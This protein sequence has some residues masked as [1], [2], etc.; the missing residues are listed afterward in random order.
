MKF[1]GTTILAEEKELQVQLFYTRLCNINNISCTHACRHK[2]NLQLPQDCSL[3]V[4]YLQR[5]GASCNAYYRDIIQC[6]MQV[7]SKY[8]SYLVKEE[9][10]SAILLN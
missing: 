2:I 3:A 6:N 1:T 8:I 9:K 7:I 10:A 4:G 5:L